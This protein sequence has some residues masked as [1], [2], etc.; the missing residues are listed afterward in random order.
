MNILVIVG[1]KQGE[2]PCRRKGKGSL[3]M[4]VSQGLV[5]PNLAHKL[6]YGKGKKANIPL[7]FKYV[8]RHKFN[9]RHFSV[10]QHNS[11]V[12]LTNSNQGSVLMTRT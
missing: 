9:F 6:S 11:S 12:M 1:S 3:A 7:L 5:G 8:W 4:F 2:N 10:G